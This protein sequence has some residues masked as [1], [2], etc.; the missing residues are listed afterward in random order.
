MPWVSDRVRSVAAVKGKIS[1]N[2]HGQFLRWER[3]K[4]GLAKCLDAVDAD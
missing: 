4:A 3:E 1:L 2:F